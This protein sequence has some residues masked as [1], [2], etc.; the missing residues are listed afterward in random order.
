MQDGQQNRL[1]GAEHEAQTE[2]LRT[3]KRAA[4]EARRREAAHPAVQPLS[5][6]PAEKQ[7]KNPPANLGSRRVSIRAHGVTDLEFE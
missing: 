3:K 6:Q 5:T 4:L 7:L 1:I 2:A